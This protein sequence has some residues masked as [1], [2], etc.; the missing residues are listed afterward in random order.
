MRERDGIGSVTTGDQVR[1]LATKVNGTDTAT[2]I[3]DTTK[4]G[5]SRK[6]FGFGP[7]PGPR[8]ADHA[9]PRRRPSRPI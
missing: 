8:H 6:G 5:A 7:G 3:A 2:N 9:R 4:M 1:V